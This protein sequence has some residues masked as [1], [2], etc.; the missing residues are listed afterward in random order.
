[1]TNTIIKNFVVRNRNFTIVRN[2]DG[3]YLAIEDKYITNGKLNTTLNGFQ[4]YAS[5]DLN[6]CLDTCQKQIEI[7]YLIS[8]GF[9]KA[10]AF[11][12]IFN[13]PV[14]EELKAA[15]A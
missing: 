12:K 15:L 4:M 2:E 6:D 10:E 7:E 1:M 3:W 11:A 5:K 13:I 8:Q 9:T 14:T